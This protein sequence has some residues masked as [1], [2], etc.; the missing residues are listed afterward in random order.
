MFKS[1]SCY[2]AVNTARS[3]LSSFLVTDSGMTVGNSLLVKRLMKGIF[4]L[5]PPM[6]RYSVIWD[7][8]IVLDY[9]KN[10]S[11][12]EEM[13]LS[14]L[15]YKL[16]MLLALTTRQRAQTLHAISLSD[17]HLSNN[18]IIIPIR[19]LLKHSSQRGHNTTLMLEKFPDKSLCVVGTLRFYLN[20]TAAYRG[21][22]Q[23]L[24]LSYLYPYRAVSKDTISRWLK[25]VMFEAGIDTNI[26]K[27]HSTRAA[28]ASAAVRDD[29]P[30]DE[31]L[32]S[33][34]WSNCRT[35]KTFYDKI[36]LSCSK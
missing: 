26:F 13:P 20:K 5:K 23:Q 14:I 34:G 27:P 11:L 12:H 17:I 22:Q 25:R 16:V 32:Q 3:A 33:A 24:F 15:T 35:F 21:K 8:N 28:S 31:I 2:S 4:E 18:L 36:I 1:G 6:S 30:I 29:V 10:F 19:K 7:V 9:L